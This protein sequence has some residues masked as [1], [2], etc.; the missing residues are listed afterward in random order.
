MTKMQDTQ[1]G[2]ERWLTIDAQR[3]LYVHRGRDVILCDNHHP[4]PVTLVVKMTDEAIKRMRIVGQ[5]TL[6]EMKQTEQT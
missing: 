4:G 6:P 3:V 1:S 2:T 5:S